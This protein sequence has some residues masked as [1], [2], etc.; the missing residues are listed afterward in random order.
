MTTVSKELL[1]KPRLPEA[2]VEIEGVGVVRVRGLSRAEAMAASRAQEERGTDGLYRYL[3]LTGLVDP[4][5]TEDEV[6]AWLSQAT[7]SE[8]DPVAIRIGELSGTMPS[9]EKEA[10][11]TFRDGPGPGVPVLPGTEAGDDG[12]PAAGRAE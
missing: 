4:S 1:L 9:S 11:K 7:V 5:L 6:D 2:E 12:G 8:I 3:L 10:L